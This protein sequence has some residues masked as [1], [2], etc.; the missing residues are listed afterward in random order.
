[1]PV[2]Q[3]IPDPDNPI[4]KS[5]ETI[6]P[7]RSALRSAG[8]RLLWDLRFESWRSRRIL[9]SWKDKFS[10]ADKAV[11]LCNGPSLLKS[12]LSLLDGVFTFGLNKIN[13]LFD[14][15]DFRPSCIVSV[16]PFVISQ[17]AE[18]FNKTDIQ[19]FLDNYGVKKKEIKAR[20]NVAFMHSSTAGFARDCSMSIDQGYTVTYVALQLAFH[21]GFRNVALIGADHNFAVNGPAN[22]TVVADKEDESHFDPNYFAIGSKWQLPDLFQSEVSYMRAKQ[23][24]E[25]FGG[26]VLNATDGGKL[27]VF[28][29]IRLEEF[30]RE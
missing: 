5:R 22:K 17:N 19:L 30:I 6:N 9:N 24:Y 26:R 25:A 7:Y 3:T 1:M 13:L 20:S 29:R 28:P 18:F 2:S 14:R 12:D 11:I 16:N 8:S 15:S 4:L 10:G 23:T 27:E 21:M